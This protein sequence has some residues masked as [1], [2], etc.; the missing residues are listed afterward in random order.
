MI[1]LV[2]DMKM[3]VSYIAS[4]ALVCNIHLSRK[5]FALKNWISLVDSVYII[6]KN[7]NSVPFLVTS[8]VDPK[9]RKPTYFISN[10]YLA[11]RFW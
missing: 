2:Y 11:R 6:V 4:S 9:D 8:L 1:N 7:N 5:L 10:I 3:N